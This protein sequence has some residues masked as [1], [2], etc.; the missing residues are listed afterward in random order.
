MPEKLLTKLFHKA[1]PHDHLFYSVTL[2][3]WHHK[4][5][6]HEKAGSDTMSSMLRKLANDPGNASKVYLLHRES[7]HSF[8]CIGLPDFPHSQGCTAL[9]AQETFHISEPFVRF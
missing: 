5:G 8:V 6:A 3:N 2:R 1:L 9:H 4:I 7:S